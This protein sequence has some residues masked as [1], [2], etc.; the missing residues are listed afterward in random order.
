[1]M[2]DTADKKSES[3]TGAPMTRRGFMEI[4]VTMAGGAALAMM[5]VLAGDMAFAAPAAPVTASD[6]PAVTF[7]SYFTGWP[8]YDFSGTAE[9]Y[10]P[11]AGRHGEALAAMS[12]EEFYR[13]YMYL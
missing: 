12:D 10:E 13:H 7:D 1:M 3:A 5:P 11:P 8:V 2:T 6:A 9:P 4:S